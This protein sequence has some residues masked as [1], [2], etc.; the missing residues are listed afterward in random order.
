MFVGCGR[1]GSTVVGQLLNAHPNF[2]ISNELRILQSCVEAKKHIRQE[3]GNL[4]K[5]AIYEFEEDLQN[6][7]FHSQT[8]SKWQKDWK[9][10]SKIAKDLGINKEKISFIGDKKQGGNSK[11]FKIRHEECVVALKGMDWVPVCVVRSPSQIMISYSRVSGDLEKSFKEFVSDMLVGI[12]LVQEKEG[13]FIKYDDLMD[14]PHEYACKIEKKFNLIPNSEWKKLV[15]R[16]VQKKQQ[17]HPK[18]EYFKI[19]EKIPE[20]K[21]LK[22]KIKELEIA[23]TFIR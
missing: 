16:V 22:Q 12:R 11:L 9:N 14:N 10:I 8:I 1:S 15:C 2:L 21:E 20:W 4:A 6:S 18:E 13:I 7:Q 5:R 17:Q 3:L 19:L 23:D